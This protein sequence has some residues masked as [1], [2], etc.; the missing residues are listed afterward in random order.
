MDIC[1]R[2]IV[3]KRHEHCCDKANGSFGFGTEESLLEEEPLHLLRE[4]GDDQIK[5]KLNDSCESDQELLCITNSANV[6]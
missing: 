4:E 6:D 2:K 3:Y 1:G 5:E